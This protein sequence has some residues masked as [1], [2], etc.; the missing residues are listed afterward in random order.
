MDNGWIDWTDWT[1]VVFPNWTAIKSRNI[2]SLIFPNST[3]FHFLLN[4]SFNSVIKQKS[5]KYSWI[6]GRSQNFTRS[7]RSLWTLAALMGPNSDERR[8]QNQGNRRFQSPFLLDA[9]SITQQELVQSETR[10]RSLIKSEVRFKVLSL[11]N[12]NKL[13]GNR[14]EF[15]LWRKAKK[16]RN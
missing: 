9:F 11:S 3:N 15:W 10:R 4:F 2:F 8:Q 1:D 14:N 16:R 13:S 7:K 12:Q 5:C 6:L